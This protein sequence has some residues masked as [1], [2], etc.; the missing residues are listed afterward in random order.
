MNAHKTVFYLPNIITPN[1]SN[2]NSEFKLSTKTQKSLFLWPSLIG[3]AIKSSVLTTYEG[4]NGTFANQ[5]VTSGVYVYKINLIV[6]SQ[7]KIMSF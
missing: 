6:Q 7:I 4:W 1:S 5:K 2:S 3:G